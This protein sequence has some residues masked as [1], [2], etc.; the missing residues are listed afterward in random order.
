ML[1]ADTISKKTA[2]FKGIA[3]SLIYFAKTRTLD[4]CPPLLKARIR[5][6]HAIESGWIPLSSISRKIA[7]AFA[8]FSEVNKHQ[9]FSFQSSFSS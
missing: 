6:E 4:G 9:V 1:Q 7:E 8:Q 5:A 2:S 3:F